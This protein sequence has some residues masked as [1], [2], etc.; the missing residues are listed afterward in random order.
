MLVLTLFIQL[1]SVLIAPSSVYASS[2]WNNNYQ[3]RT[4][5]VFNN[6]ASSE[7][8]LNFPVMVHLTG[9]NF[10]FNKAQSLGQDLRFIDSDN[11]TQL[12]YEIEKYDPANQQAVIWVRVPQ[13]DASSNTDSI[14]MYYNNPQAQDNQSAVG[15]W[16]SNYVGV[17]HMKETSGVT[18]SDSTS[19]ANNLTKVSATSPNP[20]SS[21]QMDGAQTFNGSTDFDDVADNSSFNL[22]NQM[23]LEGWVKYNS[24]SGWQAMMAKRRGNGNP[25][26]EAFWF[27]KEDV[28]NKTI[29]GLAPNG[30]P[31]EV[32]FR[33]TTAMTAGNWYYL[34]IA[35]DGSNIKMYLNGV[36][37]STTSYTSAIYN[38]TWSFR[39]GNSRD[40]AAVNGAFTNG[41][42]D[43]PRISSSS[44]SSSWIL[45]QYKVGTDTFNSFNCSQ[46]VTS[47]SCP[48]NNTDS[49]TFSTNNAYKFTYNIDLNKIP[50]NNVYTVNSESNQAA[51]LMVDRKNALWD[52]LAMIKL[53]S[54]TNLTSGNNPDSRKYLDPNLDYSLPYF[55]L[56]S[57]LWDFR[58]YAAYSGA[59]FN[60][61]IDSAGV[62]KPITIQL[63][64]DKTKLPKGITDSTLQNNL[65]IIALDKL[66]NKWVILPHNAPN[67]SQSTIA[68]IVDNLSIYGVILVGY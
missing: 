8:L 19:N 59:G 32:Q 66:T 33:G 9:S 44:R 45:A 41:V 27:G 15:V 36:L 25:Q 21:G 12:N 14:Y 18:N 2:W 35:Y 42:I 51:L 34:T 4:Q 62:K 55:T 10:D 54:L 28:T 30:S 61:F 50:V 43:E 26:E 68:N 58:F 29:L 13:V 20:T 63:P 31:T 39:V 48:T 1:I 49:S 17:W 56:L 24:I 3:D 65:K 67:I 47:Q 11:S 53:I 6:S 16:N 64:Y 23:T 37:E 38:S 7:N 5:I 46:H 57:D 22:T 60:S 52:T 40:A